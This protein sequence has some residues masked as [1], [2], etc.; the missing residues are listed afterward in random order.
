[1]RGSTDV[2]LNSKSTKP[3][4]HN[5]SLIDLKQVVTIHPVVAMVLPQ[6]EG[7][8]RGSGT[9]GQRY[10]YSAYIPTVIEERPSPKKKGRKQKFFI[11]E[12]ELTK[13]YG[14]SQP[15]AAQ[16]LGVS[17]STLKRRFYELHPDMRWPYN[18]QNEATRGVRCCYGS[19]YKPGE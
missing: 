4:D 16:R 11:S 9:G 17:V 8:P 12:Q 6:N 5:P 18:F 7:L 14:L 19:S 10:Q 13:Y 15:D 3:K 2:T 1:M